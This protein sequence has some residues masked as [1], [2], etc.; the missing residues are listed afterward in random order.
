MLYP[1]EPKEILNMVS[2]LV[3]YYSRGGRTKAMADAIVEG[4]ESV[5][6]ATG[7][8]KRVDYATIADLVDCDAVALGSPN[9]FSYMA[10]LM[11]DYFDRGLGV[12]GRTEGKPGAAFT[13]GGGDSDTALQSLERMIGSYKLEKVA[14]GI[15]SSGD[16]SEDDLKKCKAMGAALAKAA[17]KRAEEP[18]E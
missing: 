17:Q 5:E 9:Y 1:T 18:T 13:S 15:I 11:K 12:R 2:V 7:S 10:G 4:A 16:P 8:A 6:G 14:D 3:I